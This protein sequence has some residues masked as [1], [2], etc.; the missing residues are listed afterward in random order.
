MV[1][2]LA[3]HVEEK[4]TEAY[5]IAIREYTTKQPDRI[6]DEEVKKLAKERATSQLMFALSRMTFR[7]NG[8][9]VEQMDAW[10]TDEIKQEVINACVACIKDEVEKRASSADDGL[11]DIDRYLRKHG[12]GLRD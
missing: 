4:A 8:D 5:E 11:S 6:P 9:Q 1:E 2:D 10:Y 7:E 3:K 12:M